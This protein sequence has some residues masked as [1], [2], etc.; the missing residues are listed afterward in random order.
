MGGFLKDMATPFKGY[1]GLSLALV[2]LYYFGMS[3]IGQ[4]ILSKAGLSILA[5]SIGLAAA[6]SAAQVSVRRRKIAANLK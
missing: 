3:T 4:F 6:L 5:I 1:F 2:L